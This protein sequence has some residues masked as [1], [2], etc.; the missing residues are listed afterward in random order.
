MTNISQFFS[1]LYFLKVLDSSPLIFNITEFCVRFSQ[2]FKF[3]NV[4]GVKI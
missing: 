1:G 4:K 2:L 3:L